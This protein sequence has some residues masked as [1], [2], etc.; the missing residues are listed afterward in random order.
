MKMDVLVRPWHTSYYRTSCFFYRSR[1]HHPTRSA[2]NAPIPPSETLE[3]I[4]RVGH[5][6]APPDMTTSLLLQHP[7]N[8]T[9]RTNNFTTRFAVTGIEDRKS[10]LPI[11]PCCLP[12]FFCGWIF[13]FSVSVFTEWKKYHNIRKHDSEVLYKRITL[14]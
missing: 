12:Y 4:E 8:E 10:F 1:H 2:S 6:G 5:S 13:G 3:C 11:F 9:V 7:I 14:F